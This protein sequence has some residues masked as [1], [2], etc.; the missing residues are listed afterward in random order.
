MQSCPHHTSRKW[1]W[2]RKRQSGEMREGLGY[3]L[4]L[5]G[6]GI[7]TEDRKNAEKEGSAVGGGTHPSG[8]TSA[9]RTMSVC[10][11]SGVHAKE[12]SSRRTYGGKGWGLT[13]LGGGMESF[14]GGPTAH[15]QGQRQGQ[16]RFG[17]ERVWKHHTW[18]ERRGAPAAN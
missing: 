2:W 17:C 14:P 6:I 13:C 9:A 7:G 15:L 11:S 16:R 10:P 8:L 12:P 3:C 5:Q 1:V 4:I 18:S